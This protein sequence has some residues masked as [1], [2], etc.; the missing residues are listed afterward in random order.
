MSKSTT[1]DIFLLIFC[2]TPIF[3]KGQINLDSLAKNHKK[4][5]I[6][7]V[8]VMY[9]F[10]KLPNGQTYNDIKKKEYG[11][12]L[13]LQEKFITHLVKDT[14]RISVEVQSFNET[15]SLLIENE[16]T[17]QDLKNSSPDFICEILKVDAIIEVE[18]R[19]SESFSENERSAIQTLQI[20]NIFLNPLNAGG[21]VFRNSSRTN[22]YSHDRNDK[23]VSA[24]MTIT[25][26]KTGEIIK[27]SRLSLEG[28]VFNS[29][30]E[31]I[32][33]ALWKNFKRSQ[34]FIK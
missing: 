16:I 9:N 15:N 5:A 26:G 8:R 13:L 34:Y 28:G 19:L 11:D 4:V 30:D 27:E 25:D 3:S 6:L 33:K 22:R 2:L 23:T 29:S 12:G 20:A 7:P 17:L 32:E 14:N 10:K 31:I 21:T 24:M 18:I 1:K